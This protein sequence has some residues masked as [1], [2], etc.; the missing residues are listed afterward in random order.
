MTC[1]FIEIPHQRLATVGAFANRDEFIDCA[2]RVH[3]QKM[4]DRV[5]FEAM[6]V[7]EYVEMTRDCIDEDEDVLSD[8]VPASI[9]IAYEAGQHSAMTYRADYLLN[10]GEARL[11]PVSEFEA[12]LAYMTDDL[13]AGFW[14]KNEEEARDLICSERGVHQGTIWRAAL[15]EA[16][17][18]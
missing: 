2:R 5:I 11:E 15:E 1:F 3:D 8:H 10:E 16:L 14:C 18:E 6:T 4:R 9:W 7:A 13:H 17:A 12:C